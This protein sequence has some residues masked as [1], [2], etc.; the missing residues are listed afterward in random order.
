MKMDNA[1]VAPSN[2]IISSLMCKEGSVV[3]PNQ[4][5]IRLNIVESKSN[6]ESNNNNNDNNIDN[7]KTDNKINLEIKNYMTNQLKDIEKRKEFVN[8][9]LY[10]NF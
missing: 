8:K 1:I 4:P 2:G 3:K 6:V 7:E 9:N 10:F 5:L